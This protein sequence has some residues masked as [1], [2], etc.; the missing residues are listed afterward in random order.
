MM[1]NAVSCVLG[2]SQLTQILR[3]TFVNIFLT[4]DCVHSS[5]ITLSLGRNPIAQITVWIVVLNPVSPLF[6]WL[7]IVNQKRL[8][9]STPGQ[10]SIAQITAWIVVINPVSPLFVLCWLVASA[11]NVVSKSASKPITQITEVT[12]GIVILSPVSALSPLYRISVLT[13]FLHFLSSAILH[14]HFLHYRAHV[15]CGSS[16]HA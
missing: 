16:I 1:L 9:D 11:R 4:Y 8:V 6:V 15:Y 5:Q 12:V 3:P 2:S 14:R 13:R 10:I 7:L